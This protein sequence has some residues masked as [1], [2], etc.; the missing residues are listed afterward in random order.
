MGQILLPALHRI[1]DRIRNTGKKIKVKRSSKKLEGAENEK[2]FN[3]SFD[4]LS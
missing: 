1:I 3:D 2:E 4:D